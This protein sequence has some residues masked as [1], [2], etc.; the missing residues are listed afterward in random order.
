[1]P[2]IYKI[3][4]KLFIIKISLLK[5]LILDYFKSNKSNFIKKLKPKFFFNSIYV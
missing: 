1:M 4:S 5:Y 2:K 3:L